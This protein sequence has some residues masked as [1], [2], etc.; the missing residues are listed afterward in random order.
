MAGKLIIGF[1]YELAWGRHDEINLADYTAKFLIE[2][3]TVIPGLLGILSKHRISAT[4]AVVGHIMLSECDGAHAELDPYRPAHFPDWFACG[5]EGTDDGSSVWMARDTVHAI[6]DCATPQELA[7]HSFSHVVF[8]D[9]ALTAIRACQEMELTR[10]LIEGYGQRMIS[11]V[12]PRGVPG[13]LGALKEAGIKVYRI[14][15]QGDQG[16]PSALSWKLKRVAGE[17]LAI[18]PPLSIPEIDGFGMTKLAGG[19]Q[20][21]CRG[22]WRKMI[23]MSR[24]ILRAWRGIQ[25]ASRDGEVFYLWSHPADFAENPPAMLAIFDEICRRA[26]LLRDAGKLKI[27]PLQG[28]AK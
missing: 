5:G 13:H 8:N 12:F 17:M 25:R 9:E 28:L 2:R 6:A 21:S 26:A 14:H 23:P 16:N 11:H 27:I 19:L 7:S 4:W 10:E 18:P 22:R 20:L 15:A 1:D 3:K 24:R